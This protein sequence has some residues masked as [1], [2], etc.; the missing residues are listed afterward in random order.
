MV[1]CL[2]PYERGFVVPAGR[3]HHGKGLVAELVGHDHRAVEE[4]GEVVGEELGVGEESAVAFCE[5]EEGAGVRGGGE[6]VGGEGEVGGC[7]G[8]GEDGAEGGVG[9]DGGEGAAGHFGE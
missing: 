2:Q 1:I 6:G 5:V 4:E 7:A 3:L 9:V 8:D